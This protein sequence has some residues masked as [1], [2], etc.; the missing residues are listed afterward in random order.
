MFLLAPGPLH[1]QAPAWPHSTLLPAAPCF[2]LLKSSSSSGS[3][4]AQALCPT[5]V[6]SPFSSALLFHSAALVIVNGESL[7]HAVPPVRLRAPG[8]RNITLLVFVWPSL[9]SLAAPTAASCPTIGQSTMVLC[10]PAEPQTCCPGLRG[11]DTGSSGPVGT[12][13]HTLPQLVSGV[14]FS[15]PPPVQPAV[16]CHSRLRAGAGGLAPV[17][18]PEEYL[19]GV[20]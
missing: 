19:V 18:H 15:T 5:S 16:R 7:I 9:E 14:F 6:F 3:L 13:V 4:T 8:C 2:C 12:G 10:V 1:V 11:Q 20:Y 17:T